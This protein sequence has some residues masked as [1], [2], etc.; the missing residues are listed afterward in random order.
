MRQAYHTQACH[1]PRLQDLLFCQYATPFCHV[2]TGGYY[3]DVCC[4]VARQAR[5]AARFPPRP[6]GATVAQKSAAA[7]D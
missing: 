3:R 4:Y 1:G 7:R 5:V 2:V 6:A